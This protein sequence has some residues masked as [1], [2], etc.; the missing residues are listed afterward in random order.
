MTACQDSEVLLYNRFEQ[1][2]HQFRRRHALLLQAIDVGFSEHTALAGNRMQLETGIAHVAQFGRLNAK[3]RRDLVD[4]RARS[5]SAFVV[6]RRTFL[7]AAGCFIGH[8][9][10]DLGVLAAQLYHALRIGIQTLHGQTHGIHFLHEL[11][12]DAAADRRATRARHEH[13]ERMRRQFRK[14][15]LNGLQHLDAFL[16]LSCFVPLIVLRENLVRDRVND[17]ELDRRTSHVQP[18][19]EAL[20]VRWSA[21]KN[22]RA[23]AWR[24]GSR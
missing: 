22:R 4:D 21:C 23:S 8:E 6:H 15:R 12:T 3:L 5:A 2:R 16:R 13:P 20:R 18:H 1:R 24:R 14:S 7:F 17:D 19:N 10:N 9:D 11:G